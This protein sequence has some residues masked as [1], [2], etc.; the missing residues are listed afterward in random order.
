MAQTD[1]RKPVRVQRLHTPQRKLE[2]AVA[3]TLV[4]AMVVL[5]LTVRP[6]E[7]RASFGNAAQALLDFRE[8]VPQT[9][10]AQRIGQVT[11]RANPIDVLQVLGATE[12]DAR[13]AVD[14]LTKPGLLN[15]KKLKSG[16][17]LTAHFDEG[18]EETGPRLI[19][20]S[21]KTE[22]TKTL[23]ATR[24][25]DDKFSGTVLTSRLSTSFRRIAGVIETNLAD[26]IV[27]EGGEAAHAQ[28]FA[29]LYPDDPHLARGG[30]KGERFDLVYEVAVDE[31][32]NSMQSGDLIFAAFNGFRTSG[33]W[34][35]HAPGDTNL[36]EYYNVNGAARQ[37]FLTRFPIGRVPVTSGFG[38]RFHPVTGQLH[39]HSGVDFKAPG[40][41]PVYAAGDGI[42]REMADRQGYGNMV[43]IRH[44]RGYDTVYA[45]LSR[46]AETVQPGQRVRLGDLI[47][48]VG[49][50]GTATGM[51]LH[52]EIRQNG[53]LVN[54]LTIE[55]PSGR[56]LSTQPELYAEFLVRR[57]EIDRLRGATPTPLPIAVAAGADAVTAA[58]P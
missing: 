20:L 49:D 45:H 12:A 37:R 24:G 48:Y 4:L 30:R 42:V 10:T 21:L 44:V 8:E 39:L 27:A 46:F 32:G 58:L 54:P 26:A 33:S 7:N 14:A 47:G 13:A 23:M 56:D 38:Q 36:P 11:S 9:S 3:A 57:T 28:Q 1:T 22:A 31:R 15:L 19:A 40:G 50:T 16:T 2:A 35:R 34:Y 52:Y 29:A 41:T 18:A 53:R 6:D 17:A 51:H 55:L 43:L 5:F 25:A